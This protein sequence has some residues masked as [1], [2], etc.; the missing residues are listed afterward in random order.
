M[1]SKTELL[2]APVTV[3]HPSAHYSMVRQ[4]AIEG[5]IINL[6]TAHLAHGFQNELE[7]VLALELI[8][9]VARELEAKDETSVS[10]STL[11]W[12]KVN[13]Y[14]FNVSVLTA[15]FKLSLPSLTIKDIAFLLYVQR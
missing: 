1:A 2:E 9:A 7:R 10:C 14:S 8:D 6:F 4:T 3:L 12:F 15:P 5:Q 11:P 13:E